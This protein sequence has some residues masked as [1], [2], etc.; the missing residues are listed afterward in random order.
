MSGAEASLALGLISSVIAI[1]Q[2]TQQVYEAI[3]D[4]TG[5]PANFKKSALKLPLIS[6]LLEDAEQ[7][8]NAVV[9]EASQAAFKPILRN[10]ELQATHLQ[11]LFTKVMPEEDDSRWDRYV[12]AA[13]TIGKG[14]RVEDLVRGILDG[15]QLM[16]MTFPEVTTP[17]Y[18]EQLAK[19]VEEVSKMDSSLPDGFEQMPAYAH[20]GSGAQNNN[21]GSG[22][23]NTNSGRGDVINQIKTAIAFKKGSQLQRRFVITGMGGIGKSEICLK[24]ADE[25][26]DAFWGIFWV[27]VSSESTANDGFI[28][29]ANELKSAAETID[30]VRRLLS[31]EE[32]DWLLI[33]DNADDPHIDYSDYFP[34]GARGAILLTSRNDE[35]DQLNTVGAKSLGNLGPADCLSLFRQAAKVKLAVEYEQDIQ[36]IITIL[37]SHTLALVQAGAYIAQGFCSVKAYPAEYERQS[38]RLLSFGSRQLRPRYRHVYA[39]FEVSA[40]FLESSNK[41]DSEDALSLLQLLAILHYHN[42]PLK[43]FED[44][45]SG[46]QAARKTSDKGIDSLS[47]WHVSQLPQFIQWRESPWDSFRLHSA[48]NVLQS[49]AL[50][51]DGEKQGMR[52]ISLHPLVH[53]WAYIRQTEDQCRKSWKSTGCMLALS[54]YKNS[55]WQPYRLSLQLHLQSFLQKEKK[56]YLPSLTTGDSQMFFQCCELMHD[57]RM[58]RL[59]EGTLN[60]LFRKLNL[61]RN[62]PQEEFLSLYKLAGNILY[63]VGK[64]KEAVRLLEHVVKVR[65]TTLAEDHPHRLTSQH[66]LASVYQADGQIKEAVRLL[67]HV[68]KVR[69][70]TLAEDHPDRLASQHALAIAYQADG[71]I[72]EAV[73]LLKHVVKVR[74]TT[75]AEDHPHRLTSQHELASVY[76]ADGQIKEAVRLLE[77]VVKVQETTLVEDHPSRLA[78]QHVLATAYQADG[79]IKEA[80]RLLEHVVKVEETTLAEDHPDRLASQHALAIA[81]QADGQIKEAVQLLEHVVKVETTLAEDHP[82][83]LA[84]RDNLAH[85]YQTHKQLS[86]DLM[87]N[88]IETCIR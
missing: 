74:E 29:I 50:I 18:K 9:D 59:A 27:D 2:A 76:Q 34:S 12:K 39:T 17:R 23:L 4:A 24:V 16:T 22:T 65:E 81:Y 56:T 79:Q 73:Q 62:E 54:Y 14:G 78:S 58:D 85:I 11:E 44:A 40:Q 35:C 41:E 48:K 83:R 15:L 43:L 31:N 26:R 1:I 20:Y 25:M 63:Y 10:C 87:L 49:L 88:T 80:V 57:L 21:T 55:E 51:Q 82:D 45:W 75:L 86:K 7:Y 66:E 67:E 60:E 37:D 77:H 52:T 19:A 47:E 70:T 72:K 8:V 68:V 33:L 36:R 6:K 38:K 61:D 71:Q 84:S 30:D 28:K 64:I 5:L 13:R 46:A 42:V 69:E 32:R 3:D 53:T